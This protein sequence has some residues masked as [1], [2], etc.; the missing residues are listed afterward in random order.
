MS[1]ARLIKELK[2][3]KKRLLI[4]AKK[5]RRASAKKEAARK[6]EAKLKREIADLKAE[7]S[8]GV[9]SKLRRLKKKYK[10][11]ATQKKI[12]T[13]KKEAKGILSGIQKFAD[14]YG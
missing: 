6:E 12:K 9:T 2:R 1:N 7:T 11:P 13:L 5:K 8:K 10:S 3:E 14:K 4:L